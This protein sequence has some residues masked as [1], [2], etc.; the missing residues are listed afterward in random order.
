MIVL[1]HD[2]H[3]DF[4]RS[5]FGAASCKQE[6]TLRLEVGKTIKAESV[7]IR[8]WQDG[9]GE[10]KIPMKP[11]EERGESRIYKGIL[12]APENPCVLWYYFIIS[13][14][15]RT[16]YYGNQTDGLG[17]LGQLY[18]QEPPAYQITVYKAGTVTPD[19][20]KEAVMY[21]I[22]PDRFYNG[23]EDGKILQPKK[24]SVLQS[25]WE[26]TPYY[27]RD[28]DTKH[29]FA[30]DFF[31]G[32]LQ[33]II[34]KLPYLKELGISV[35]YLNPI[36]LSPSN[37]RYDTSDYKTID[38]MLGDEEKF[39][40]LCV[41]AKENGIHI[42]L[43]GVFS[44]TGS[45][46][47]YFNREGNFP[48]EGA[49]Q[50]RCSPY[51]SWYRFRKYPEEYECW[52]GIDT[53]PNVE[54]MEPSYLDYIIEGED[55][56]IR[57]WLK[58]G[59]RGWRLDVADELPDG[60]I[61]KIYETM[62][63]VDSDSVLL[64]EVWEDASRKHSYGQLRQYVQGD[65][66][67][68]IMNYPFRDI[69]LDFLLN[70]EDAHATHR[71]LMSL[72]ENYPKEIFYA[73]MNLVGTHDVPRV[74]TLLGEAPP[75][76]SMS[77]SQQARYR[78]PKMRRQLA[79]R[80]LKLLSLWQMTFP[81]VPS[82]YYGDEAGLEGYK[83]PF[84]RGTYPWGREDGEI[85][86][87]YKQVTKLRQQYDAFKKGDFISLV[88]HRDVYAFVRR[89]PER[90]DEV[91][92]VFLNRSLTETITLELD[93]RAWC[94][95]R[96]ADVLSD[97]REY[98]IVQGKLSLALQ[99][100]EGKVLVPTGQ[101][102]FARQ[103]GILLHPTA[104]PSKYGIGDLGKGAYEFVDF[105][106]ES[107]QKIWQVLPVNPVG[108]G[109]SPYQCLSAFAGHSLLI[110]P[111]KLVERG[112][113][114]AKVLENTPGFSEHA[115]EFVQVREYKEKVLRQAYEGFCAQKHP[116]DYAHFQE[117]H[118]Y[119]LFD[120]VLFMALRRH[121]DGVSWNLWPEDI[122]ARK[123][124]ALTHYRQ[125]LTDEIHYQIFLQYVFF[126]Q[127]REL[128]QYAGQ[129]GIDIMGDIPI[130]VAHD[131][132]DVWANPQL[133]DLDGRGRPAT[134]AG[135]PPDY[136]SATGQLWG[137]PHYRWQEMEKDDYNWWRQR[138]RTLL[139]LVDIVRVDH[140]RG[141]EAFWEVS[142]TAETA[143]KGRW[144][145]GPGVRFF[146][147]LKNY[148]PRLPVVVED[149]GVITWEVEDLK[150][151]LEFPGI[152]VMHFSF[153]ED[154]NQTC[155]PVIHER[156]LVVY[157]GTHDNDT[158]C[159][160]YMKLLKEQPRLAKCVRKLL[161]ADKGNPEEICRKLIEFVYAGNANTVIIP[162]Q[163][164]LELGT[165]ARMNHPGTVGGKNWAWRCSQGRICRGL[166]VRLARLAEENR[167]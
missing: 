7:M 101:D 49:C 137:N 44:H 94:H 106:Q 109:E 33:G 156:N 141:F 52:W 128:R 19:W 150:Y 62:K 148:F 11:C 18:E 127:W 158:T 13:T 38:P 129:K 45:D 116:E 104:L 155:L 84:N 77:I 153:Q 110:S 160:W 16:F 75:E 152:K 43:D 73:L 118:K 122:A 167:R 92:M 65:E 126:S 161:R 80:R 139:L 48:V 47:I 81:G 2:S 25:H 31:G 162:M 96:L 53:L 115:V 154:V 22:F 36:F 145:K 123:P 68:S 124:A 40:E 32:N 60:F 107:K 55:S 54:E 82:I 56:V 69:S 72:Y 59:A 58:L 37:H 135:V 63:A 95:G 74:L 71:K 29:I 132:S 57:H 21:Q 14:K 4:F 9:R 87:W 97:N 120:Y 86:N 12:A 24:N 111:D 166:A 67:D 89:I 1:I 10:T 98:R 142:G 51:F 85:L 20:F 41:K 17:G 157:T 119:W 83:D 144:V 138:L 108:Y 64:G 103:C 131:S 42:M 3:F 30:Y 159:G 164:L 147:V 26:N 113:L 70:R 105:L 163:D 66:L 130:F 90:P 140:F 133:F 6:I 99:P 151:E 34:A 117:E 102:A 79:I 46:S 15:D 27:V 76:E 78:L 146:T 114:P 121:F 125:L 136:F 61:Q 8:L 165:E 93:V 149:L 28:V 23:E 112:W 39:K 50:S 143:E 5:P 88:P 134:V 100:L 35:I 91:A